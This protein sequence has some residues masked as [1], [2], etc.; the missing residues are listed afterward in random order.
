[1]AVHRQATALQRLGADVLVTAPEVDGAPGSQAFPVEPHSSDTRGT[2]CGYKVPDPTGVSAIED[3]IRRWRPDV[4]YDVHGTASG[5]EAATRAR[6]PTA[7]LV[8]DYAWLCPRLTMVDTRRRRCTGPESVEKCFACMNGGAAPGRRIVQSIVRRAE[9]SVLARPISTI[10]ALQSFRL[11]AALHRSLPHLERLRA[12]VDRFII[13]D[14]NAYEYFVR[15]GVPAEKAVRIPQCLPKEALVVRRVSGFPDKA[16]RERPVRFGF[17]GRLDYDKG[18]EVLARA[19][20]GLPDDT[21]A[22]LWIIH[23]QLAT[24]DK[25][26]PLFPDQE[27]FRRHVSS[28]R[29]RLVRPSD[30][31]SLYRTMGEV[32]V[33]VIPSLAFESPSYVMLEF[34]AQRTPVI[35]S[36]SAGMEHVIQ[37]GINGRTVPY[38]DVPALRAAL[39]EV[40]DDPSLLAR[41]SARLPPIGDDSEY[42]TKLLQVFASLRDR[43]RRD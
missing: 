43:S 3:I 39:Q 8:G 22:E 32:D 38:D 1:V 31:E 28:G 10:G 23:S 41:W 25:I 20:H 16:V 26:A 9:Q 21:P 27:L 34:A 19:F 11:W 7:L 5:M 17:V 40:V 36:E 4:V 14:R 42:A 24:A 37:D 6:I 35:R 12:K 29:I 30:A 2:Y 15:H 13:G 33:G 18:L